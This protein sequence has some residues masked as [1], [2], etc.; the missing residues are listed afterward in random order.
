M[1]RDGGK[2]WK[3]RCGKRAARS[4]KKN[5][6]GP[7][8]FSL[9]TDR[10]EFPEKGRRR[11]RHRLRRRRADRPGPK[12]PPSAHT[13]RARDTVRHAYHNSSDGAGTGHADPCQA[14]SPLPAHSTGRYGPYSAGRT[15]RDSCRPVV[16]TERDGRHR[17]CPRRHLC[18][19]GRA[20]RGN[21]LRPRSQGNRS[22]AA[23][24]GRLTGSRRL[25]TFALSRRSIENGSRSAS[26][27]GWGRRRKGS[28]PR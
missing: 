4:G 13:H 2:C 9:P 16:G 10:R 1:R 14:G 11:E 27:T 8:G 26:R 21:Q 12:R 20:G 19:E 28:H 15:G 6:R 5:A 3:R 24:G 18:A 7:T 17:R 25:K 22:G 23:V